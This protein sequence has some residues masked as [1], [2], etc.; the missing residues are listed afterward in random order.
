[1]SPAIGGGA[2]TG[3]SPP[4][5]Q[6]VPTSAAKTRSLVGAAAEMAPTSVMRIDLWLFT[7]TTIAVLLF[8]FGVSALPSPPLSACPGSGASAESL[9]EFF[10]SPPPSAQTNTTLCDEELCTWW[11]DTGEVNPYNRVAVDAV[12]QSRRYWVQ[13]SKA[14]QDAFVDSFVYEAIPRNGNGRI[15][16]PWDPPYSETA[17]PGDGI[18]VELDAGINMAWSQ[19]EFAVDVDVKISSRDGTKLGPLSALRPLSLQLQAR[20]VSDD[21]IVIRVPA[22]DNGVRFSVEFEEDLFLYRSNGTDY[23]LTGGEVVGVEPKHALL[24]FASPFLQPELI[25][26]VNNS[27]TWV[28]T[29]GPIYEGDWANKSVLY[30]PAGVYYMWT[31][32]FNKSECTGQNHIRLGAATYWVYFAPGAYV[33]GAIEYS[34]TEDDLFATGHGVVSGEHY[35]YQANTAQSYQGLKSDATSLRMWLHGNAGGSGVPQVWTCVGPTIT[36]PPFNSM[37]FFNSDASLVSI[38]M[39]DYAQVGAFFFQTDGA[40]V[41]PGSTIHDIFYHVNDDAIKIYYSNTT[42]QRVIVWKCL[43]DPVIQL[44]WTSREVT[45]VRVQDL[46]VVHAR[47]LQ[48]EMDVPSALVGASPFYMPG[49]LPDTNKSISNLTISNLVCEGICPGL[50]RITPLQNFQNVTL[51][52]VLYPDGLPLNAI[53]QGASIVLDAAVP[54]LLFNVIIVNWTVG[55]YRIQQKDCTPFGWAQMSIASEFDGEWSVD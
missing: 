4:G 44:G 3:S 38:Q 31:D 27:D 2:G 9:S 35:V 43:N 8:T 10:E 33:K 6:R 46:S 20:V 24:I 52:N 18:S 13:V 16:S 39:Y 45:N 21:E 32:V 50:L 49:P 5:G 53:G 22:S 28:M 40:Q 7:A 23:V 26:P 14:D 19:F 47:Y 48:S 41:Y 25:P 11:H 37:D 54:D 30:F 12:R 55:S 51:E 34:N 36:S 1:M 29:P 17:P 15:Y 42:I